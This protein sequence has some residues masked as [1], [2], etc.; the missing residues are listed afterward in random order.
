M[1]RCCTCKQE[2]PG[3]EFWRSSVTK[4]GL[5]IRC[6]DC[7]RAARKAWMDGRKN[8]PVHVGFDVI[9]CDRGRRGRDQAHCGFPDGHDVCGVPVGTTSIGNIREGLSYCEPHYERAMSA[10]AAASRRRA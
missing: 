2:K 10:K 9:I 1:K 7:D 5:A 8:A 3:V 4:D 6:K